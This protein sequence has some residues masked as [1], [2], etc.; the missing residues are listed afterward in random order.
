M[1]EALDTQ[2]AIVSSLRL[3]FRKLPPHDPRSDWLAQYASHCVDKLRMQA[4]F[5]DLL[6][7]SPVVLSSRMVLLLNPASQALWDLKLPKNKYLHSDPDAGDG[8]GIDY[9]NN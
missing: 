5:H 9:Y 4:S 2:L 1:P 7:E 3:A 6:G 8:D